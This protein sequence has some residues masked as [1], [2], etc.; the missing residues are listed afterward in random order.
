M[1]SNTLLISG[2]AVGAAQILVW[3]YSC[4]FLP[5]MSTAIRAIVFSF[6]GA[7]PGWLCGF[8]MQLV[9][10]VGRFGVSFL[11]HTAPGFQLW[12]YFHLYMWVIIH[13]G[14][15]PEAALE[16]LCLPLRGPSVELGLHRFWQHQLCKEF[17]GQGNRKYSSLE[18]YG[19]NQYWPIGSSILA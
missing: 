11:S 4:V 15:A 2:P 6:V 10:L 3:S 9:Q 18:G 19:S 13:W 8:K 7:L 16:D 14:L 17:G 12:F 5:P 1:T